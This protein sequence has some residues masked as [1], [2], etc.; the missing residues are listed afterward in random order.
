MSKKIENWQANINVLLLVA[1]VAGHFLINAIRV[2][3]G[4]E[5]RTVSRNS[6]PIASPPDSVPEGENDASSVA[7]AAMEKLRSTIEQFSFY[8]PTMPH[9]Y[10]LFKLAVA[11]DNARLV[12]GALETRVAEL[13]M[14][15]QADCAQGVRWH[16]IPAIVAGMQAQLDHAYKYASGWCVDT[17]PEITSQTWFDFDCVTRYNEADRALLTAIPVENAEL[18]TNTAEQLGTI[19]QPTSE[20]KSRI[21]VRRAVG[22]TGSQMRTGQPVARPKLTLIQGG[23]R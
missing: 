8:P 14:A 16:D 20:P 23:R 9:H 21:E 22:D 6:T 1:A 7:L 17:D 3:L 12:E 18:Q 10:A 11:I 15:G 4:F 5:S 19:N 13:Q 2:A